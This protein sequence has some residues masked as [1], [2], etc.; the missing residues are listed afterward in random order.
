M[1]GEE[2]TNDLVI[3]AS[4]SIPLAEIQFRFTRSSG[5]GGQHANKNETAVELLF[6]L[7]HTPQLTEDQRLL[8]THRLASYLDSDGVM[9]LSSQTERSQLRNRED[10]TERFVTLLGKALVPIKRRIRRRTPRA[11]HENRLES[12]RRSSLVKRLRNKKEIGD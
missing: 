5:P 10:V 1:A 9:H 6:D 4:V 11:A 7:A 12:K 3:N 2:T 8:A